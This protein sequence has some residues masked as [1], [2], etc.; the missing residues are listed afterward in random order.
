IELSRRFTTA[1]KGLKSAVAA[2]VTGKSPG[3]EEYY[4]HADVFFDK[5][6]KL[7]EM[8]GSLPAN[9]DEL[10]QEIAEMNELATLI[11]E[12]FV[13]TPELQPREADWTEVKTLFGKL[14]SEL[15][16]PGIAKKPAV[17]SSKR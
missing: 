5:A 2:D 8:I 14:Q 6:K 3:E 16:Q 10:S 7:H 12:T 9:K 15:D 11:D 17:K 4:L 1:A 13:F